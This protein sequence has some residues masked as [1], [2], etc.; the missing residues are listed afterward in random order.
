MTENDINTEI[1]TGTESPDIADPQAVEVNPDV[2]SYAD[3]GEYAMTWGVERVDETTV[4][5]ESHRHEAGLDEMHG[6]VATFDVDPDT[7]TGDFALELA[8]AD[9]EEAVRIARYRFMNED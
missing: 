2:W 3:N 4:R 6:P 7:P 8:E 9:P 5:V 1:E